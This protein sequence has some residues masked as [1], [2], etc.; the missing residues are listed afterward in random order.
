MQAYNTG[1]LIIK[2][3][4]ATLTHNTDIFTYNIKY[5]SINSLEI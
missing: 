5:T 3:L 1:K 2:P 4:E